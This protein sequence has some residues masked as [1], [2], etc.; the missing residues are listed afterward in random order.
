MI[1]KGIRRMGDRLFCKESLCFNTMPCRHM[2]LIVRHESLSLS[3]SLS[4]CIHI[5]IYIYIY[6]YRER[7]RSCNVYIYICIYTHIIMYM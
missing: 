1:S 3:L 5:Y 2:R 6:T 7:E 4:M